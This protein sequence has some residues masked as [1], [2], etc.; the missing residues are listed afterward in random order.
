MPLSS[1]EFNNWL[2]SDTKITCVLLEITV[3]D[4]LGAEVPLYF[5]NRIFNTKT[6]DTPSNTTYLPIVKTGVEYTESLPIDGEATL[7]Y[8]DLQL[9]NKSG[10]FDYLLEYIWVGASIKI[11]V[12]DVKFVRSDFTEIFNGIVGDAYV[13]DINTINIQIRDKLQ[14]LNYPIYDTLVGEYGIYGSANPNKDTV[15]PLLFGEAF[16]ISPVM[17]DPAELEYMVHDGPV[18]DIVEVRDN[19]VPVAFTKN[20]LTGTFKLTYAPVGTITCSAVGERYSLNSLGVLEETPP[21]TVA[22]II[23]RIVTNY[24]NQSQKLSI[25]DLDLTNFN[26]F[27]TA[28]PQ[29]VGIYIQDRQNVIEVCQNLAKSIGAQVAFTRAGYLKLLKIDIPDLDS[30]KMEINTSLIVNNSFSISRKLPVVGSVKLGYNYNYTL[31]EELLTSIPQQH[32][33]YY[34]KD[35][36][37]VTVSDATVKEFYKLT[38]EAVQRNTY[39]Q[40]N[41]YSQVTNEANRLLNL[42]KTQRYIYRME[43][44]AP[45]LSLNV[46]D[47]VTLRH[48]RYGLQSGKPGQIVSI[49][50][51]WD[52]NRTN[53]EV[54]V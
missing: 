24:G 36:L 27:N 44:L 17:I 8:G 26:T 9:I 29:E 28:H 4:S 50:V 16:N 34:S 18:D 3:L 38:D 51:N 21:K 45:T 48:T 15:R 19:G 52:T 30:S 37:S 22:K 42:N 53:I 25:S 12:G 2:S 20:N 14:R 54:L 7:S 11:F 41:L 43:C 46:G 13:T 23:S 47:M 35:W 6:T 31:Q 40:S 49:S 1:I 5:S 39:I 32:K 10:E 33:A